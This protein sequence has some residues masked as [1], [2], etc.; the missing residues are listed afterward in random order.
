MV[1]GGNDTVVYQ[2][3]P[4]AVSVNLAL[5][6]AAD[7][8]GTTDTLISIEN[9]SGSS[10]NDTLIGDNNTNSLI[11]GPGNDILNGAGGTDLANYFSSPAGV[12]V[13]LAHG[14]AADGF[15][16]TDTL[17]SIE[18]V[19]GSNFDD[20]FIGDNNNNFFT[21]GAGNDSEEQYVTSSR[22]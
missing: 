1:A 13:D 12:T 9:V 17:I 15:G 19:S 14:T 11:G 22:C 16:T 10:F 7:G 21:G 8:Y 6:T 4:S 2:N 5:G 3:D 18:N 20:T